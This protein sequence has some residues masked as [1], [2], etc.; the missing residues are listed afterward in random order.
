MD[1]W[2]P[3]ATAD[4]AFRVKL[5]S[6]LASRGHLAQIL[7]L[8]WRQG[9]VS[10]ADIARR[11][12]RSRSTVS[13]AVARLLRA[14]LVG[15]VGSGVSR[16]GRRPILIG[17]RAGAASI[18]GVDLGASHISVILTDLSGAARSWHTRRYP[19]RTDPKGAGAH[20]SDLCERC[21]AEWPEAADRLLGVGVGVPSPVDPRA[22]D[23]V[24]TRIHPAWQGRGIVDRLRNAFGAPVF[25]D[26]DANLGAVAEHRWGQAVGVDDFVYLKVGTGIG[27]GLMVGGSIYRGST[28]V[29]GEIGHIVVDPQ[30][31][32]CVCGGRGCLAT[33]VGTQCLERRARALLGRHPESVLAGS[34][35]NMDAIEDA[36]LADDS[37][38]LRI[39]DEAARHLGVVLAGVLNLMNPGKVIIGG[40]LARVGGRLL[41]PLRRA[42]SERTLVA[43]AAAADLRISE[44]G[45]R[46]IALG[47]ATH[48]LA[49]AIARPTLF[50]GLNGR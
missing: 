3:D 11:T 22:P 46:C 15:E 39:V 21:L 30:G 49:A 4:A 41:Q 33:V 16:G 6:G 7:D 34:D 29:A 8:V 1:A 37:L 17:L 20:V 44:L 19:V 25:V 28:G 13:D 5:V 23:R 32:R 35:V 43:S 27:A 10:R 31:D 38:A 9:T 18:L 45:P 42:V 50:P 2:T 14:E 36:A 48:V 40:G 12:G 47:A 26:N 24:L